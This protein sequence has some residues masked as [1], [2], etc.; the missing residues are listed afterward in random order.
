MIINLLGSTSTA[1]RLRSLGLTVNCS[2]EEGS[3]AAIIAK[4]KIVSR[5][6]T[7]KQIISAEGK[8]ICVKCGYRRK[9]GKRGL[10]KTMCKKCRKERRGENK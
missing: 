10:A 5:D 1:T 4:Y 2:E 8:G 7:P 3:L 9:L 6:L